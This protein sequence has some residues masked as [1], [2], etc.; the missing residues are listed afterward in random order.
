MFSE[1]FAPSFAGDPEVSEFF[2]GLEQQRLEPGAGGAADPDGPGAR[3]AATCSLG[4]AVP[5]RRD[6]L[7]SQHRDPATYGRYVAEHIPARA[8]R[9]FPGTDH[10]FLLENPGPALAELEMLV[11][12]RRP[13]P[14]PDRILATV[15]FT[16]IV[17]STERAA[18]LGDR[19]WRASAR[20]V[21]TQIVRD[22]ID[23]FRGREID[24]G[25]RRVL[26]GRSTSPT[27]AIGCAQ[28]IGDRLTRPR[29][30]DPGRRAHRR[31]RARSATTSAASRCTSAR[32]SR[33]WP[34]RAR[35]S[36]RAR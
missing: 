24:N 21:I 6:A 27:R 31:V 30:G 25:G 19:E 32:A 28:S 34:G 35:S 3:R 10:A 2:A 23:R 36:C 16:D 12:G 11:T 4:V 1:L 13:D 15:L 17:G 20:P 29:P 8:V 5:T 26:R 7:G 9:T 33:R 18:V 14:E 22:E